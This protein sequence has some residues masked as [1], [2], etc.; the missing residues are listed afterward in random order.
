MSDRRH[1]RALPPQQ[2]DDG[3]AV[4]IA[5]MPDHLLKNPGGYKPNGPRFDFRALLAARAAWLLEHGLAP[6]YLQIEAERR[7]RWQVVDRISHA[8]D[9]KRGSPG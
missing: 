3:P 4:T 9:P 6:S 2:H 8:G 5:D 7:R 1:L